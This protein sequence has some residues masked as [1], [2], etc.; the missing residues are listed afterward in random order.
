MRQQLLIERFHMRL[1]RV[2]KEVSGYRL[3]VEPGGH[4]MRD[5]DPEDRQMLYARYALPRYAGKNTS[6]TKVSSVVGVVF[7]GER[8][9]SI[10][11]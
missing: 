3:A 6:A 10:F 8:G 5:H 4:K 2:S 9:S 1:H 7:A 11:M